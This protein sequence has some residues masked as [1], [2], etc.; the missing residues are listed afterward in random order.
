MHHAIAFS[1]LVLAE[2]YF[3]KLFPLDCINPGLLLCTSLNNNFTK[4]LHVKYH[5]ISIA[6]AWE[7][8]F[9]F[10]CSKCQIFDP[11]VFICAVC[12]FKWWIM[13]LHF[14]IWFCR[15]I[16]FKTVPLD[17]IN[18]GLLHVLC[19]SLNHNFT[20]TTSCQILQFHCWFFPHCSTCKI[21]DPQG[22]DPIVS[23]CASLIP[24]I[25]MR[26]HVIFLLVH[27][28]KGS[29]GW[30]C[31]THLYIRLEV[32]RAEPVSLTC[33]FVFRNLYTEPSIGASYQISINLAKCF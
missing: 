21:C 19:T 7:Y 28:T 14:L 27:K 29:E 30:A 33:H 23:I 20:R 4:Q 18:P 11:I 16:F 17:C 1:H 3:F 2:R 22:S 12:V 5:C 6:D 8:F 10:H 25:Q 32:Q 9:F 31:V 15:K 24:Y 13:Q 26:S